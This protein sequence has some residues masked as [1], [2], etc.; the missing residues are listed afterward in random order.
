RRRQVIAGAE[1]ERQPASRTPVVLDETV[2]FSGV[3]DR[4]ERRVVS[5]DGSRRTQEE[6]RDRIATR[7]RGAAREVR[8]ECED[9]VRRGALRVRDRAQ[10]AAA[11]E[12]E[13]MRA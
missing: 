2:G 11:A 4:R 5:R 6:G 8:V 7:A 1:I 9:A 12:L 10:D 13:A 3:V